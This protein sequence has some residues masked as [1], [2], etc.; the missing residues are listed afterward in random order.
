MSV[1]AASFFYLIVGIFILAVG[2]KKSC[3]LGHN[4][5]DRGPHISCTKCGLIFLKSMRNKR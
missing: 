3:I 5:V 2:V 4:F 1:L